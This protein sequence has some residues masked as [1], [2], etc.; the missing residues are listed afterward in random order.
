MP[1]A[2]DRKDLHM[3]CKYIAEGKYNDKIIRLAKGAAEFGE[4]HGGFF[5]TT[6]EEM[7]GYWYP[8]G[9]HSSFVPAWRHIWQVFEDQGTNKYAT[10]VWEMY[11]LEPER[12]VRFSYEKM[13]S[14]EKYYP[15]DKYV[16]W[17]GFSAFSRRNHAGD[18]VHYRDLIGKS[19][20]EMHTNHPNTPIMHAEFGRTRGY[21]QESYLIETFKALK[22]IPE[23]KAW[24]YYDNF[25]QAI[26]EE[27]S[28]SNESLQVMREIFQ[29]PYWIM[30]REV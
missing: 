2:F 16:D 7:N 30:A 13:Q 28:L 4:K 15:G 11:C 25:T 9:Q 26:S 14:P 29:D 24:I 23:I 10:W 18:G 21:D 8:W 27:K 3:D 22:G 1:M 19:L 12:Q 20:Q 6:M 17:I 5:V